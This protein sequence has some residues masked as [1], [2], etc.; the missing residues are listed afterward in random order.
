MGWRW[1]AT[2]FWKCLNLALGLCKCLPPLSLR[3]CSSFLL[4]FA[5]FITLTNPPTPVSPLPYLPCV[6]HF[7]LFLLSFNVSHRHPT[8]LP[9]LPSFLFFHLFAAFPPSSP[10][11]QTAICSA[12]NGR[13][14]GGCDVVWL[15]SL[16]TATAVHFAYQLAASPRLDPAG[17]LAGRSDG[18]LTN[19]CVIEAVEQMHAHTHYHYHKP[20][21]NYPCVSLE[22][23]A[24]HQCPI[25]ALFLA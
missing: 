2:F 9:S 3:F 24:S 25:A 11:L 20:V 7:S 1:K 12:V 21:I 15:W 6:L 5:L 8:S 13:L 16:C 23:Q 18:W 10:S 19:C 4:F 14:L 22:T 17:C